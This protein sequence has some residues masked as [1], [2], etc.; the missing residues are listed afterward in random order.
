MKTKSYISAILLLSLS[1]ISCG[2]EEIAP[3]STD[4]TGGNMNITVSDKGFMA[5]SRAT[6]NSD[7][8]VTF[9]QGDAIGLFI[10]NTSEEEGAESEKNLKLT[11]NEKGEWALPEETNLTSF[12]GKTI[13]AYYPY[14]EDMD[15]KY[16]PDATDA[17]N[18]FA[19]LI[20][21]WN[22]STETET[23]YKYDQFDLMTGRGS[24]QGKNLAISLTH[25][26]GLVVVR[27]G[28]TSPSDLKINGV[29]PYEYQDE[30]E[31]VKEYRYLYNPNAAGAKE[32]VR[33]TYT[34][35]EIDKDWI[36]PAP[37]KGKC[38]IYSL[39]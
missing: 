26:M 13:F 14:Q 1:L 19:P 12:E 37:Q 5:D 15:N 9:G 38:L 30:S 21:G 10:M 6:T 36:M 20:S 4:E 33:I 7:Y 22:T 17:E 31:S 18:F 16:T 28:K 32:N 27:P 25:Q 35:G 39:Q 11:L 23:E 8:T 34:E 2:K 29:T 24:M 3:L